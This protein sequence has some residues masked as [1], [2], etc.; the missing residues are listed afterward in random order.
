MATPTVGALVPKGWALTQFA[1]HEERVD[2]QGGVPFTGTIM[3]QLR[4]DVGGASAQAVRDRDLILFQKSYDAFELVANDELVVG[5]H[6][7]PRVQY[8]LEEPDQG[9]KLEQWVVYF[10]RGTDLLMMT[11]THRMGPPFDRVQSQALRLLEQLL[12]G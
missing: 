2:S 6:R 8:R 7:V 1:I 5:A 3:C 4:L 12:V 10:T 9:Q 11:A